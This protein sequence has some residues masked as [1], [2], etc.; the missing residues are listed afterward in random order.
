MEEERQNAQ[1][2]Q[3]LVKAISDQ[4]R[5]RSVRNISIN[6]QNQSKEPAPNTLQ[7]MIS[8]ENENEENLKTAN[9]DNMN[10]ENASQS[11]SE[12]AASQIAIVENNTGEI[13][14]DEKEAESENNQT[15]LPGKQLSSLE[16]FIEAR[17]SPAIQRHSART[18]KKQSFQFNISP[19]G[20]SSMAK[21][22]ELQLSP[23]VKVGKFNRSNAQL[24]QT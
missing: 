7:N 4:I 10:I 1:L 15:H 12:K 19:N 3:V 24:N 11:H 8:N 14:T 18:Q 16:G 6:I 2:Q 20:T 23:K 22:A 21:V 5:R 17:L 13:N 9:I